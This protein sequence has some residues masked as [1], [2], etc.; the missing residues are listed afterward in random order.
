MTHGFN[1]KILAS[2]FILGS[3]MVA[4]LVV[5]PHSFAAT[6]PATSIKV[7]GKAKFV[8]QGTVTAVAADSL[9]LHVVKTS[10]NAKLFDNKDTTIMVSSKAT[11]TKNAKNILLKQIKSGDTVKVFGIFDKKNGAITLVRWVKVVQK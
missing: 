9:V 3:L 4:S 10:K 11:L 5:L 8:L 6:K 2:L 1:K 7:V